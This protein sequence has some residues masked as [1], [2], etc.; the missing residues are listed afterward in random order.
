MGEYAPVEEG[1][2]FA[3]SRQYYDKLE[4]WL[5]GEET[6]G[7]S[8]VSWRSSWRYGPGTVA[9]AAPGPVRSSGGARGA[10]A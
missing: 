3:C 5:A 6:T 10:P 2:A 1:A 9:A 8:M 4:Q 7:R